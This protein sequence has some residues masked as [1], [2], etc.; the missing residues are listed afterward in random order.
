M[1]VYFS[2]FFFILII[3]LLNKR[4]TIKYRTALKLIFSTLAIYGGIRYEYGSDYEYYLL[5]FE[6]IKSAMYKG[7][8]I[9]I[10]YYWLNKLLPNFF[11]VTGLTSL[12]ISYSYYIVFK[13]YV[14]PKYL[15]LAISL[16]FLNT[17]FLIG[18]YSGIR[19]AIAIN[20]FMLSI[21]FI[22]NRK[23]YHYFIAMLIASLFHKS[24][25]LM[26]PIYFIV[27]PKLFSKHK[28]VPIFIGT[29]IYYIVNGIFISDI[30]NYL[31]NNFFQEYAVYNENYSINITS[32]NYS[33]KELILTTS[34]FGAF[35]LLL[36]SLS[37]T[38]NK[39][40]IVI[41]RIMMLYFFV[42]FTNPVALSARL[43]FY[44]GPFFIAGTTIIASHFK[45]KTITDF[46]V[47]YMMIISIYYFYKWTLG[48]TFLNYIIYKTIF[49]VI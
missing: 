47:L 14:T 16:L 2:L 32:N 22:V 26:L 6:Q 30:S 39:N 12:L 44:F 15:W 29:I 9:E 17:M 4:R 20:F 28:V 11:F 37:E 8:T 33:Y 19:N 7:R 45:E 41:L 48:S 1:L 13:N 24:A 10:G 42:S 5:Y 3:S 36:S 23:I 40:Q 38:K 49:D 27:T 18:Q 34:K 25:F 21:P 31:T 43:Y 35:F 46:F